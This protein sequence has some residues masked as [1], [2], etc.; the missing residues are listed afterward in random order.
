MERGMQRPMDRESNSCL[1]DAISRWGR[2][3]YSQCLPLSQLGCMFQ[4]GPWSQ[5]SSCEKV[6]SVAKCSPTQKNNSVMQRFFAHCIC[7]I[8]GKEGSASQLLTSR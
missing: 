7:H 8:V 6:D 2:G 3:H 5:R 4:E 1:V